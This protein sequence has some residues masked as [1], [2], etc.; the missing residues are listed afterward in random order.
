MFSK[1]HTTIDLNTTSCVHIT[2]DTTTCQNISDRFVSN[3]SKTFHNVGAKWCHLQIPLAGWRERKTRLKNVKQTRLTLY[4]TTLNVIYERN[5]HILLINVTNITNKSNE[6]YDK[7]HN[8]VCIQNT[9]HCIP[10]FLICPLLL[11]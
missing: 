5:I 7:Q 11:K 3:H 8:I 9:T 1:Y 4:L 2:Y 6:T 10:V